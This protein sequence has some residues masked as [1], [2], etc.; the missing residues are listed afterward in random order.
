MGETNNSQWAPLGD[1]LKLCKRLATVNEQLAAIAT[2]QRESAPPHGGPLLQVKFT[3][4]AASCQLIFEDETLAQ[5]VLRLLSGELTAKQRWW[6]LR[7][8][9]AVQTVRNHPEWAAHLGQEV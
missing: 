1:L 2:V 7:V 4:G 8:Q 5:Q 3:T 9:Q 6:A